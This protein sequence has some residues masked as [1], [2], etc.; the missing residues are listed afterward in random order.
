MAASP[1]ANFSERTLFESIRIA[2]FAQPHVE[3]HIDTLPSGKPHLLSPDSTV[4]RALDPIG[5]Y[6]IQTPTRG[7]FP[8]V[9]C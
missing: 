9:W 3:L 7:R 2:G 6:V 8:G 4:R 1:I 5:T